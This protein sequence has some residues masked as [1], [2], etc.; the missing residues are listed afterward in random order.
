MCNVIH[1]GDFFRFKEINQ[2]KGYNV[3]EDC[4]LYVR[5]FVDFKNTSSNKFLSG[6]YLDY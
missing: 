2:I 3:V 6:K 4:F 5:G 1:L